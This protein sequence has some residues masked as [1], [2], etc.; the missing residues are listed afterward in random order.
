MADVNH[1][2]IRVKSDRKCKVMKKGEEGLK[3]SFE[4]ACL[5]RVPP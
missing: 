5:T 4:N 1:V 3:C 2:M